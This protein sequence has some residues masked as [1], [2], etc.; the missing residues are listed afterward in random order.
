MPGY[1]V[2]SFFTAAGFDR[3]GKPI[4]AGLADL[5]L[6]YAG[7]LLFMSDRSQDPNN[8]DVYHTMSNESMG[9]F[10]QAYDLLG[11]IH[12]IY[13]VLPGLSKTNR[14]ASA[15]ERLLD[16][17]LRLIRRVCG[18]GKPIHQIWAFRSPERGL[19]LYVQTIGQRPFE[20]FARYWVDV[21]D[22]SDWWR[23]RN[24]H[25]VGMVDIPEWAPLAPR[26]A[27]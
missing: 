15:R 9:P 16:P 8:Y 11:K 7:S 4:P 27:L 14:V 10:S 26:P 13:E 2:H 6:P 3:S 12:E 1:H 19:D 24:Y 25:F 17:R 22:P 5:E 18:Y 20:V 23:A 21:A